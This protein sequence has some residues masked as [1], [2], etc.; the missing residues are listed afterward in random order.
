MGKSKEIILTMICRKCNTTN[1]LPDLENDF[2]CPCG[3]ILLE[4]TTIFEPEIQN[5]SLH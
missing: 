3:N 4:V 1:V 5:H 2:V